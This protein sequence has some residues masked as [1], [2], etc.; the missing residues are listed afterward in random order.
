MNKNSFF[1]FI[2]FIL[3]AIFACLFTMVGIMLA[4]EGPKDPSFPKFMYAYFALAAFFII[5]IFTAISVFVYRDSQKRGM[6]SWMWMCI[7]IF[8]PNLIGLIIYIIARN[9]IET[10]KHKCIKCGELISTEYKLC[11]YCGTDLSNHCSQCG[12]QISPD[13]STCPYCSNKL[14]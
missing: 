7:A 14:K 2:F 1:K 11:P 5:A 9:K 6:D 12:K 3:V 10:D 8:V 4:T 13:W